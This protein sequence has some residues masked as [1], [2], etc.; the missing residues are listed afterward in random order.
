MLI[1]ANF[2]IIFY[3]TAQWTVLGLSLSWDVQIWYLY[4]VLLELSTCTSDFWLRSFISFVHVLCHTLEIHVPCATTEGSSLKHH[5]TAIK[6]Y[7]YL[8]A[9]T[10]I[11][12]LINK[13]KPW[14][15][16]TYSLLIYSNNIKA[17]IYKTTCNMCRFHWDIHICQKSE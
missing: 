15:F 5:C 9:L 3:V 4:S 17:N 13:L 7:M 16:N 6:L 8:S 11:F 1:C 14:V 12:S 2:L 10:Q